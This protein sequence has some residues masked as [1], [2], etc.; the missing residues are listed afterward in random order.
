MPPLHSFS[1]CLLPAPS[2]SRRPLPFVV[3]FN[4]LSKVRSWK[5]ILIWPARQQRLRVQAGALSLGSEPAFLIVYVA[6]SCKSL[7]S[8]VKFFSTLA[9][10][11]GSALGKIVDSCVF[12]SNFI[13]NNRQITKQ[14][15][16]GGLTACFYDF[17]IIIYYNFIILSENYAFT[18]TKPTCLSSFNSRFSLSALPCWSMPRMNSKKVTV[19]LSVRLPGFGVSKCSPE[20]SYLNSYLCTFCLPLRLLQFL[21]YFEFFCGFISAD[22]FICCGRSLWLLFIS[23]FMTFWPA[24]GNSR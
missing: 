20:F 24:V 12:W 14:F 4:L 1:F 10:W 16:T 15:M 23:G 7:V 9:N 22:K 8:S 5:N 18:V 17:Y 19:V 2:A 11:T 6:W 13:H 21:F 3:Q